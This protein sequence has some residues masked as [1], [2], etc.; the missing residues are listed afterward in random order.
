MWSYVTPTRAP[1]CRQYCKLV[2]AGDSSEE[3]DFESIRPAEASQNRMR[4]GEHISHGNTHSG[5]QWRS[6]TFLNITFFSCSCKLRPLLVSMLVWHNHQTLDRLYTHT[7]THVMT[8]RVAYWFSDLPQR[9][10]ESSSE[11]HWL[12]PTHA[13][14]CHDHHCVSE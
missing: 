1:S 2:K 11:S 13:L 3:F 4:P 8:S 7:H 6:L 9:W 5:S 12:A 14:P 10:G